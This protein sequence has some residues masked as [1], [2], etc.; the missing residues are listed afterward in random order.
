MHFILSVPFVPVYGV[1]LNYERKTFFFTG[2]TVNWA[3]VAKINVPF[4]STVRSF[5]SQN[6]ISALNLWVTTQN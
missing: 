2:K 1:P 5:G 4:L 3:N 6:I